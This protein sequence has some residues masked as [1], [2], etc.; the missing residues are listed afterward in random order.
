M[1]GLN[2]NQDMNEI[3]PKPHAP[4][5]VGKH[6]PGPQGPKPA[7]MNRQAFR[8]LKCGLSHEEFAAVRWAANRAG[9]SA[10]P[11][12]EFFRSALLEKVQAIAGQDVERG[13]K[14]PPDITHL[15]SAGQSAFV[16]PRR[17]KGEL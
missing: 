16:S 9:K 13:R 4:D 11:L 14:L 2:M 8:S 1:S 3:P 10:M 15:I 6:S 7:G 12:A 17:D 5:S